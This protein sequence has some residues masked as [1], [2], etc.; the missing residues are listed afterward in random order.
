MRILRLAPHVHSSFS[1]DSEWRLE[2][3][4]AVLRR[5]GFHGALVC[6]HDRELD[7][8]TWERVID[9][10]DRV[11]D[12]TGF[13][14][15]PGVEY[16]DRD[17]VVHL[18]LFGRAPFQGRSPDIS[19]V[20]ATARTRR[21]A[22]VFAHPAR[23]EAWSRFDPQWADDLAGIEVWNRKYDGAAPNLW[24]ARTAREHRLLPTVALDWH[25]PR[26]LFP[27]AL[28]VTDPGI[29]TNAWRGDR[30]LDAI[31]SRRARATAFGL[32]VETF[33][34]GALSAATRGME[35]AREWAAPKIRSAEA[36]MRGP[37]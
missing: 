7:D 17:H 30:V 33:S 36:L 32:P 23:R 27:L 20:V 1:D 29:G 10:C 19:E 12:E 31:L 22:A 8:A 18:P 4:A 24:A 3:L 13:L 25:G 15:V 21:S 26:Q 5:A 16:Q 35:S 11:G 28:R 37:R 2:R 9:A 14:L 6:D 34:R